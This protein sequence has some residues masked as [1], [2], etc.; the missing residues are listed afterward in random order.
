M[1]PLP[2]LC[3]AGLLL[4]YVVVMTAQD[5]ATATSCCNIELCCAP[6]ALCRDVDQGIREAGSER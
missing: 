1:L 5:N 4:D 3:Q 2:A 6:G